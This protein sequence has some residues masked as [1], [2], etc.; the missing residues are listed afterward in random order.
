VGV[1][2]TWRSRVFVE[3]EL[4]KPLEDPSPFLE[5]DEWRGLFAIR[6]LW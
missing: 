5:R 2:T 4:A 3:L 6:T 1:R